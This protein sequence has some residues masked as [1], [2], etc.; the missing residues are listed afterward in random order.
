[1]ADCEKDMLGGNVTSAYESEKNGRNVVV[2]P[3]TQNP[4]TKGSNEGREVKRSNQITARGC[5]CR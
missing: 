3:Y 1:M 4:K 5:P 2:I